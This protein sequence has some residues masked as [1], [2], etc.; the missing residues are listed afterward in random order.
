[1]YI[2]KQREGE[3]NIFPLSSNWGEFQTVPDN[4]FQAVSEFE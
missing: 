1:M 3:R 4:N 2:K